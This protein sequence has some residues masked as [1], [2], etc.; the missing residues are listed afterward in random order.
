M[1]VARARRGGAPRMSTARAP[2]SQPASRARREDRLTGVTS[3]R[4]NITPSTT[5]HAQRRQARPTQGAAAV[6][7]PAVMATVSWV[8]VGLSMNQSSA[9]GF[10]VTG[11]AL[12]A[13]AQPD[14]RGDDQPHR[15][16]QH[17]GAERPP[18]LV[19]HGHHRSADEGDQAGQPGDERPPA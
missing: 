4:P 14:Q 16:A 1:A 9:S 5:T 8:A 18:A 13:S 10:W 2:P 6:A 7:T 15:P 3:R 11:R 19:R 17:R 12:G